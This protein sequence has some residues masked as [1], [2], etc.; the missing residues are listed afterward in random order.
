MPDIDRPLNKRGR[1]SGAVL[2]GWLAQH[3][4]RPTLVLCSTARRT[5]ETLELLYDALGPRTTVSLEPGLYLADAP[6]LLDRL[7]QLDNA[8]P[9]VLLIAHNPGLQELAVT[10][11]GAP[12][13]ASAEA[14]A[15]LERKY[16]TAALV[17]FGIK[18]RSWSALSA[19]APAGTIKLLEFMTPARLAPQP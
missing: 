4:P 6:A 12:G 19:Q 18:G 14:R 3:G 1:R 5:R 11:A 2:A 7:R 10:L 9:S 13:A 17:R 15:A 16:P 8:V